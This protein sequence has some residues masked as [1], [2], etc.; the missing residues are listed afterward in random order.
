MGWLG[1]ASIPTIMWAG[2]LRFKCP[3]YVMLECTPRFDLTWVEKLSRCRIRFSLAIFGLDFVGIPL[4]GR[5]LWAPGVANGFHF[6]ESPVV[7]RP[8]AEFRCSGHYQQRID[9][10]PGYGEGEAEVLGM[11]ELERRQVTA[12]PTRKKVSSQRLSRHGVPVA[13]GNARVEISRSQIE[14]TTPRS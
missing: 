5:R 8:P 3:D 14:A 10:L 6:A 7:C 2:S 9:L 13:R 1:K 12:A 11:G 4:T